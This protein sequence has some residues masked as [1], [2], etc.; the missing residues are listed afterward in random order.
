MTSIVVPLGYSNSSCGYCGQSGQRSNTKHSYSYGFWSIQLTPSV[1]C[2]NILILLSYT[3]EVYVFKQDYNNLIDSGWRRSGSYIY[4]PDRSRTC[5]PQYTI[6][7]N[8]QEFKPSRSNKQLLNK[9]IKFLSNDEQNND[10]KSKGKNNYQY[11]LL[12]NI[13]KCFNNS[14]FEIKLEKATYTQEKYDLF[15]KYQMGIHNESEDDISIRSFKNFLIDGPLLSTP[16]KYS[17]D[18]NKNDLPKTFG[19][20]HQLV[21]F[22]FFR[23]LDI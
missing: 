7:L 6:K 5:C 17:N 3:K 4:N 11:N 2:K 22:C 8:A 13:Y 19:Q 23:K 15:K 10:N 9:F 16:I 18:I 1:S 20:Y 12:D 14:K 21:S